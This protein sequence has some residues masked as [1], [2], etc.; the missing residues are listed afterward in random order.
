MVAK[1]ERLAELVRFKIAN[2]AVGADAAVFVQLAVIA[3]GFQ[4]LETALPDEGRGFP[5]NVEYAFLL[6]FRGGADAHVSAVD[7]F[8]DFC[9]DQFILSDCFGQ[10]FL[11]KRDSHPKYSIYPCRLQWGN[12]P[13][14]EKQ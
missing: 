14:D 9:H 12:A 1:A 3:D 10:E 8:P 11:P 13:G 6:D 4:Q 2:P 5:G 7:D